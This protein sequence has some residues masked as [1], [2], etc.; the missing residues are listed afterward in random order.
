MV[1]HHVF[2]N[3]IVSWGLQAIGS[4]TKNIWDG[5][6][7]VAERESNL[8]GSNYIVARAVDN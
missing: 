1:I 6:K 7:S 5:E 2:N 3:I 4:A 8:R